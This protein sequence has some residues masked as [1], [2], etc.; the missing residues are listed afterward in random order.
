MHKDVEYQVIKK[1]TDFIHRLFTL[2]HGELRHFFLTFKPDSSVPVVDCQDCVCTT[3]VD[4][5]SGL[6]K[7]DCE[8]KVCEETCEQVRRDNSFTAC[9]LNSLVSKDGT[10]PPLC[11]FPGIFI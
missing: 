3:E 7:I 11:S 1:S 9:H 5:K 6:F 10:N 2:K 4:P 8:M